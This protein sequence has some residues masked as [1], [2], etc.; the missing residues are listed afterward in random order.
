MVIRG[1]GSRLCHGDDV[2]TYGD[3]RG[4]MGVQELPQGLLW[5]CLNNR[6]GVGVTGWHGFM[7]EADRAGLVRYADSSANLRVLLFTG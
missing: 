7:G 5:S 2:S 3:R 4:S 1:E 6:R